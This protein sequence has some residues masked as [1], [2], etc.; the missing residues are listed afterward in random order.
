MLSVVPANRKW[1]NET[2]RTRSRVLT[3]SS[4]LPRFIGAGSTC[5][6]VRLLAVLIHRP[7]LAGSALASLSVRVGG[8][9]GRFKFQRAGAP[10]VRTTRVRWPCGA[11]GRGCGEQVPLHGGLSRRV[12]VHVGACVAGEPGALAPGSSRTALWASC[13][14]DGVAV[15]APPAVRSCARVGGSGRA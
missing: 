6:E 8:D 4:S 14:C 9:G 11:R 15:V 10:G 12:P 13:V 7:R 1:N 2:L 5:N 3:S